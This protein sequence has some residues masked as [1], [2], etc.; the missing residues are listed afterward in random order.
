MSCQRNHKMI[1][2]KHKICKLKIP[3]LLKID[4]LCSNC[5]KYIKTKFNK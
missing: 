4:T 5:N 2:L 1:K 3:N